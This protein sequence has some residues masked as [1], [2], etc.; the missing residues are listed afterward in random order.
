M[1][2]DYNT[3]PTHI[4][5]KRMSEVIKAYRNST[6]GVDQVCTE[7]FHGYITRLMSLGGYCLSVTLDDCV[8]DANDT[9]TRYVRDLNKD[10]EYAK[11]PTPKG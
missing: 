9:F 6:G 8:E 2:V 7:T 10:W 1:Q 5:K 4:R 11:L 3:L